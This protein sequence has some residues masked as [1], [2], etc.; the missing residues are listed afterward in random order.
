[1]NVL[2]PCLRLLLAAA[3]MML[4]PLMVASG[5]L[6]PVWLVPALMIVTIMS[7]R[8]QEFRSQR[9]VL[10]CTASHALM[11]AVMWSS[12]RLGFL[13]LGIG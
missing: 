9:D 3:L 1:M 12:G 11:L 7:C 6:G 2:V 4:L 13:L 10:L 8:L 5:A